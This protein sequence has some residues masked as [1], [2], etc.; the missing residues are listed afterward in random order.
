MCH[1]FLTSTHNPTQPNKG[2]TQMSKPSKYEK[3]IAINKHGLPVFRPSARQAAIASAL[4]K[5]AAYTRDAENADA[6]TSG[7]VNDR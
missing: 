1:R 2:S 7:G 6:V 3:P 4:K 5:T